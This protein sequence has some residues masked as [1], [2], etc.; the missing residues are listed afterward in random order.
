MG[1]V[2]KIDARA[3]DYDAAIK[4]VLNTTDGKHLLQALHEDYVTEQAHVPGDP[5]E[6]A[7]R[8][9]QRSVAWRLITLANEDRGQ[10][11]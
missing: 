8:D 3:E 4:R 5:H 2:Q 7:F 1:R 6:T 10:Y 9:G 11:D